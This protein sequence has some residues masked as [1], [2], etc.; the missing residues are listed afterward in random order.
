[1]L[2]AAP[3]TAAESSARFTD[4]AAGVALTRLPDWHF[5][6]AEGAAPECCLDEAV[7]EAL[8]ALAPRTLVVVA[9]RPAPRPGVDP[10]F[11]VLLAEQ[12]AGGEADPAAVL[13]RALEGLEGIDGFLLLEEISASEVAGLRAAQLIGEY[14]VAATGERSVA[15]LE[16]IAVARRASVVLLALLRAAEDVTAAEDLDT[17]L[18]S[19]EIR[20]RPLDRP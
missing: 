20:P 19:I 6:E 17:L 12:A 11:H 9:A 3:S 5:V 18:N 2:P 14:D 8:A 16:L 10:S 4:R 15:H 7:A 1:M 13:A